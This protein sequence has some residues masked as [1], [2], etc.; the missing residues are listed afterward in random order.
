MPGTI[1][2]TGA[3]GGLGFAIAERLLNRPENSTYIFTVRN[4]NA[5]NAKPLHD[6]IAKS[7][8]DKN[9]VLAEIDLSCLK[10]VRA[11]AIDINAKVAS[12][13]LPAIKVLILNAAAIFR[14]G[15]RRFTKDEN[16]GE[17]FEVHFT[18]NFLANVLL[19]LSLLESIDRENGRIVYISSSQHEAASQLKLS[20]DSK[21]LAQPTQTCVAN[22]GIKRYGISKLCLVMFM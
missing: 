21:E 6:L 4:K 17:G 3:A 14:E 13:A 5:I 15:G 20:F 11:F 18:V 7:A 2:V 16:G 12:G 10:S 19:T 22:E 9:I 8:G 1:I